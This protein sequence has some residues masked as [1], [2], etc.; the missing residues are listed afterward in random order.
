[1]HKILKHNLFIRQLTQTRQAASPQV[2][3]LKVTRPRPNSAFI[4][5]LIAP[6]PKM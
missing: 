2:N 1:M 3:V 6:S 4:L 5:H